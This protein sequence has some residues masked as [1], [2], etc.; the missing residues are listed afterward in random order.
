MD[1]KLRE[2]I[3]R[4]IVG[5]GL[6]LD[7]VHK[8][9]PI[10]A[11]DRILAIPE[12]VNPQEALRHAE[13]EIERLRKLESVLKDIAN[14]DHWGTGGTYSVCSEY[15]P[16]CMATEALEARVMSLFEKH[17]PEWYKDEDGS[18]RDSNK[19]LIRIANV[20]RNWGSPE[21][22]AEV[23]TLVNATAGIAHSEKLGEL[24]TV[25]KKHYDIDGECDCIFCDA[26][27][28]VAGEE[29]E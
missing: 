5:E 15:C 24:M 28:A 27:R 8:I 22:A 26:Y 2:K 16:A 6:K 19:N 18:Y 3:A 9:N 20:M 4:A 17:P 12:I 21:E 14:G 7:W 25:L 10:S 11:A 23:I 29:K 13:A 1:E